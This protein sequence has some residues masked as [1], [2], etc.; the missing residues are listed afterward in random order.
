MYTETKRLTLVINSRLLQAKSK[1][2][3]WWIRDFPSSWGWGCQL[4]GCRCVCY[5]GTTSIWFR[6]LVLPP[7]QRRGLSRYLRAPFGARRLRTAV[8]A[9][10]DGGRIN[11]RPGY[12][13]I[14]IRLPNGLL[15]RINILCLHSYYIILQYVVRNL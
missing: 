5:G 2:V 6:M 8:K 1:L 12:N 15:I 3:G 11:S 13:R 9:L 4:T 7:P 10:Q 14:F